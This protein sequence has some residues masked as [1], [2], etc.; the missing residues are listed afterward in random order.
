MFIVDIYFSR[1]ARNI[2]IAFMRNA[3]MS[4][5]SARDTFVQHNKSMISESTERHWIYDRNGSEAHF[6][7]LL[8][9]AVS[10]IS[11]L[12]DVVRISRIY[13]L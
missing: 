8:Y 13:N 7:Q 11:F 2:E 3:Y 10:C 5:E 12:Y 1:F 9:L 6:A 4:G